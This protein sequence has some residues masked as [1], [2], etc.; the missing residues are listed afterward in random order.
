[1]NTE[2][3]EIL[4]R[5]YAGLEPV[6]E[7]E[8]RKLGGIDPEI[9]VRGV[10]CCGDLGFVYKLNLMLRTGLR[11][12]T[13]IHKFSFSSNE[14]FYDGVFEIPWHEHFDVDK[15]MILDSLLFSE[16]FNNS[17][18]V[19]Q[20]AKDAICD[21]FRQE[22]GKRPFIDSKTPDIYISI[23]VRNDEVTVYLDSSGESL[24]RRGYRSEQVK[25]P[26]SEVMAAGIILMSGWSHHFPFI[27]PM[28]G[29]GTF[30]IE[31]ALIADKIPPGIFRKKFGFQ[32]WKNFDEELY[33]TIFESC[34]GRIEQTNPIILASDRSRVAL[35]I[36]AQNAENAGV[37]DIVKFSPS[38]FDKLPIPERKSFIFMNPPYGERMEVNEINDLYA[39]IG[40]TF[41]HRFVGCE[42]W[43]FSSNQEALQ[44][45]G[46]KT[47]AKYKLFNGSLECRLL[48]YE[49]YGGSKKASKN[50]EE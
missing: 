10:T 6:L 35:Q 42:A 27:D 37:E 8:I 5:T 16:R 15:T 13:P 47:S 49:M 34:T 2:N 3:G 28:C 1:M 23:Y 26:L 48:R 24:H 9:I 32:A 33:K 17:M 29:S 25:A 41:K 30:S 7:D 19:S 14:S 22:V 36:A 45:I 21:R 12:L 18:F 38:N 4:V 39:K 11:V 46:L 31:A 43:V 40:T 44:N 20:L 50:T